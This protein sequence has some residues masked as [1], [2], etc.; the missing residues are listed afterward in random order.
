MIITVKNMKPEVKIVAVPTILQIVIITRLEVVAIFVGEII[1]EVT[2]I[3]I[4]VIFGAIIVVEK[5]IFKRIVGVTIMVKI[6]V[7]IL[8]LME[9]C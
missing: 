6:P 7:K 3:K 9:V 1:L 4:I 8:I 2:I 5:V